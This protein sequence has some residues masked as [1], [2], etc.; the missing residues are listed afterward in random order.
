M[1]STI[2]AGA[3]KFLGL[4]RIFAQFFQI[5]LTR[6]GR[7][8]LQIFSLKD[9]EDLFWDDLQKGLHVFFCKNTIL[10]APFYEIKQDWEPF[11]PDFH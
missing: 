5:C 6:F 1:I 3:S 4:R 10:W 11:C 2:G 7:L 9:H 8:C